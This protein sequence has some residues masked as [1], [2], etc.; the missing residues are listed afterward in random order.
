MA[1][2]DRR[3][4]TPQPDALPPRET[5]PAGPVTA[6]IDESSEFQGKLKFKDS[7]QIDG[8]VDGEIACEKTL[9]IG[10]PARIHAS[11]NST[12]VVV[13]GEVEGDITA[14]DQ[15]TLTK[16]ARLQGNIR[17]K[18][19]AIEKGAQFHG[20]IATESAEVPARRPVAADA[21]PAAPKKS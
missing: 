19:I 3:R 7:V 11:V 1:F 8:K 14:T 12:S 9:T 20:Q 15:V 10:E 5:G 21:A 16:T 6:F 2:M 13:A 4:G 17:T 18:H